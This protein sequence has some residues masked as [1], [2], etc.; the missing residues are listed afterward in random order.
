MG[1][2]VLRIVFGSFNS[3]W[4][5]YRRLVWPPIDVLDWCGDFRGCFDR[6]RLCNEYSAASYRAQRPRYR[7]CVP[8]ARQPVHHQCILRRENPRTG[9]RY[10]V[11]L[12]RDQGILHQC[13]DCG[14]SDR[15]FAMAYSK[16]EQRC[17]AHRLA[18][19]LAGHSRI[20]WRG[21][22][23]H[24]VHKSRVGATFGLRKPGCRL[25]LS[26]CV[27][28]RGG[29]GKFTDGSA[30]AVQVPQFQRSKPAHA[31]PLCCA[32]NLFFSYFR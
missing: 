6:L 13:S 10:V 15:D 19:S 8:R 23:L 28:I 2:R 21:L 12:H 3:G 11:R 25:R 14:R 7:C 24:R 5:F 27:R 31:V 17:R 18:G 16:P 4:R 1:R 9:D 32:W 30:G 26:R 29:Q 20:R 22:W